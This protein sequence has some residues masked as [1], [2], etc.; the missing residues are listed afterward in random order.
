MV[1]SPGRSGGNR[2]KT[3]VDRSRI[4]GQPSKPELS[5]A[6]SKK[7]DALLSQL[8]PNLLRKIDSHQLKLLCELL[9]H[10]DALANIVATDP[11]DHKAGRMLVNVSQQVHRLSAVFG[12]SPFD[13][14]RID[15][16]ETKEPSA[17]D[18][19]LSRAGA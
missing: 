4:D 9:A 19:W 6:A 18:D 5:P 16:P 10:G 8:E 3:G 14:A 15:V 17:F 1:G 13:R 2:R 7:W 12:L 11:S